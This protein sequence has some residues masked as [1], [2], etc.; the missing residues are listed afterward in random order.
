MSTIGKPRAIY[1]VGHST[2]PATN[3]IALL[4]S[5]GV[6][7]LGDV[8]SIPRSRHNP[9]F[10]AD[11]LAKTLDEVGIGYVHMPSLGGLRRTTSQSVNLGWRNES[12]R[13]YADYMQT[14]AFTAAVEKLI[15]LASSAQ[16]AIMCAEAVPWRCH[17]SLI[18]DALV[19]RGIEALEIVSTTRTTPHT[20]TPFARVD[21]VN[22]TYPPE[23]L[24][25]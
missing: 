13:G 16:T 15:A 25:L 24:P 10:N 17:R 22:L 9:Q 21:G 2:R 14:A 1:T 5:H 3:F 23:G 4:V 8:R 20:L 6:R 12:F 11:T 18:A 7:R 19:V